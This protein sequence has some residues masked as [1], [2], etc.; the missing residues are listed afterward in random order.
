[1]GRVS[2]QSAARLRIDQYKRQFPLSAKLDKSDVGVML[3]KNISHPDGTA[4]DIGYLP[5][6]SEENL[7]L[8]EYEV[9]VKQG[10]MAA[11]EEMLTVAEQQLHDIAP[12]L[13]LKY[14]ALVMS[15]GLKCGKRV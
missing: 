11:A 13:N 14:A 12:K 9:F 2:A 7:I 10:Y 1:M 8:E 15:R 5:N 3:Y 4:G 6:T